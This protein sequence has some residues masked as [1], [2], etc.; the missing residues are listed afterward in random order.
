M[1]LERRRLPSGDRLSPVTVSEWPD[2]WYIS[3]YYQPYI[4]CKV[5][6]TPYI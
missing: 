5:Y 4:W 1:A 6:I 3:I 2:I